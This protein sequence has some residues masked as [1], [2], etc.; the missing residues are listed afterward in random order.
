MPILFV[1]TVVAACLPL[2]W[3]APLVDVSFRGSFA[4]TAAAALVPVLLAAG[5]SGWV[6][7]T[8][9]R[10][11]DRRPTVLS[12]YA[13]LRRVIGVLNLAAG[14]VAVGVFGW[15]WAAWHSPWAA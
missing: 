5:L 13:R 3:P 1:L 7:R 2:P 10:H 6:A 14:A 12:R 4:L 8:L 15:G 11:P 9:A